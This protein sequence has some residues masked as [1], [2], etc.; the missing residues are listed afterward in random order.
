MDHG[1]LFIW[2][3]SSPNAN[4]FHIYNF[5]FSQMVITPTQV[6]D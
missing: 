3:L 2:I 1:N 6:N 5:K 4:S